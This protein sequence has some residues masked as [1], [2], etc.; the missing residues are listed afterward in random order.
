MATESKRSTPTVAVM[1]PPMTKGKRALNKSE[2]AQTTSCGFW[3]TS[4]LG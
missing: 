3:D 4:T 1:T 2:V